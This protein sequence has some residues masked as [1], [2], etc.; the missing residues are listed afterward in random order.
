MTWIV[1]VVSRNV[2]CSSSV[3][4]KETHAGPVEQAASSQQPASRDFHF[5]S[6]RESRSTF[7]G[8]FSVRSLFSFL[9]AT[10]F[11][12]ITILL[13]T[14]PPY[15][16]CTTLRPIC[17][18]LYISLIFT[19]C[20][21]GWKNNGKPHS[22][23]TVFGEVVASETHS[24]FLQLQKINYVTSAHVLT[25]SSLICRGSLIKIRLIQGCV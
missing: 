22:L 2:R 10:I 8:T 23:D 15:G 14:P 5:N 25:A 3:K 18:R 4:N 7:W 11:I 21:N 9:L 19:S 12:H 16:A 6:S 17:I 20:G 13:I 1:V 24:L